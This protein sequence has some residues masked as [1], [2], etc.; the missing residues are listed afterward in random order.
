MNNEEIAHKLK[1]SK[2]TVENQISIA[3][4]KL[5]KG[6]STLLFFTFF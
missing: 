1:I 6:L 2:H 4:Q 5:Q 3:L